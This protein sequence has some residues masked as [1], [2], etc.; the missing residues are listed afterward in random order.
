LEI[1]GRITKGRPDFT[2][3]TPKVVEQ[4]LSDRLTKLG[5]WIIRIPIRFEHTRTALER[6][7]EETP[8]NSSKNQQY[9]D[10]LIWEAVIE[11]ASTHRVGLVTKDGAFCLNR[12]TKKGLANNL[13]TEAEATCFGVEIYDDIRTLLQTLSAGAPQTNAELFA[14]HLDLTSGPQ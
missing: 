1:F 3:P 4:A 7:I 8:P 13:R 6:I 12:D 11:L 14:S 10:S 9:K 2:R 5:F